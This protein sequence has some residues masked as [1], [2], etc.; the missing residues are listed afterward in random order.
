MNLN[1]VTTAHPRSDT[2]VYNKIF[3]SIRERDRHCTLFV[4]DGLGH[5]VEENII[6]V[7]NGIS[8]LSKFKKNGKMYKA[9]ASKRGE[10]IH[11]HDPELIPLMLA[12]SLKNTIIFDIHED[13]LASIPLRMSSKI[14]ASFFK[15][16]LALLLFIATYRFHFIL[17]ERDYFRNYQSKK[18]TH[19]VRNYPDLDAFA[20]LSVNSRQLKNPIRLFYVGSITEERGV[21]AMCS[22]VSKLNL[23]SAAENFEL[24]LIGDGPGLSKIPESPA[25]IKHGRLDLQASYR[26]SKSCHFGL[27]LLSPTENY[28]NSIPTKILEY[29]VLNLPFFV[30]DFPFYKDIC[31]ELTC[32]IPVRHDDTDGVVARILQYVATPDIYQKFFDGSSSTHSYSW[33]SEEAELSRL[34]D[35][36]DS[37]S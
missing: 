24:H 23:R 4:A 22:I 18:S 20:A 7:C 26:L 16:V 8:S 25:I 3:K 9:L 34:Y 14:T 30:S 1:H 31:K 21:S 15:C 35:N 27:C 37:K 11:F 17:A 19:L 10:I 32:A 28:V 36:L 6:D 12:L 5:D 13:F 29:D 2:R 33:T